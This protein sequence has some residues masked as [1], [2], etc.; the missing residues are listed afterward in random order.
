MTA[1]IRRAF[2]VSAILLGS[3][4]S[5]VS[6]T[7]VLAPTTDSALTG[8]EEKELVQTGVFAPVGNVD[9]QLGADGCAA[10]SDNLTTPMASITDVTTRSFNS[11]SPA[12]I[13][14]VGTTATRIE[15]RVLPGSMTFTDDACSPGEDSVFPLGCSEDRLSDNIDFTLSAPVG[16]CP[17]F[18]QT[19]GAASVAGGR[20]WSTTAKLVPGAECF[21]SLVVQNVRP[22]T[23]ADQT[24]SVR[25][26]FE[27]RTV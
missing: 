20:T 13:R 15:L 14:N 24:D 7:G 11:T 12:C 25:W 1:S 9:L 23:L 4:V 19:S 16:A 3:I 6:A 26:Q 22:L 18:D 5:G 17:S 27:F 8:T 2:L 21:Y 10:F